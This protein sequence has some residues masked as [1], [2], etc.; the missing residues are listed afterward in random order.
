MLNAEQ[1]NDLIKKDT[2]RQKIVSDQ[3]AYVRG[4][5]P[6][7]LMP[8]PK[9][10]PDN[11]IPVPFAR[12][13]VETV[14]GYLA[15]P[16]NIVYKGEGY[17]ESLKEVFEEND[18]ELETAE[19]LRTALTYGESYELHWVEN[20]QEQFKQVP[21]AQCVALWS[22]SL[23]PTMT[24]F[25]RYWIDKDGNTI[26]D[27]YDAY[28]KQ[29]YIKK[30]NSQ[31]FVTDGQSME[32]GYGRVP[33]TRY[34]IDPNGLNVF[35]HVTAL[36]D[37]FD[38][39]ISENYANDLQ[40]LSSAI[41]LLAG[42]LNTNDEDSVDG[43]A[44]SEKVVTGRLRY[45]DGL[46]SESGNVTD[47]VAYLTKNIDP[48]FPGSAAAIIE[49]LIYEMLQLFNPND[50]AFNTPSGV[51]AQYKLIGFEYLC[52]K[53]TTYF[54]RGLNDRI[55][56]IKGIGY[57]LT[58]D[59][60][61]TDVIIDWKRNLPNDIKQLSE[62][63]VSLD[64]ILSKETILHMFPSYIVENVEDEIEKLNGEKESDTI[65]IY[66]K[67]KPQ[68]KSVPMTEDEED[69]ASTLNGDTE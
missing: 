31:E 14:C 48:A 25:V 4:L 69:L 38:K 33:V 1:L 50:E 61:N 41:L 53:I 22:D 68:E 32:H 15:K 44:D 47:K 12:R 30:K 58:G 65:D 37:F 9:E 67:E 19:L 56:I 63:A 51:A 35:D 39:L 18:E 13:A 2:K 49:R 17:D 11:R 46:V 7:I 16:G 10:N 26:S 8:S 20:G 54:S 34:I 24:E 45:L 3:T 27:I 36:I 52:T 55:K 66:A 60:Q 59:A 5:N 64:G 57:A 23:K 43:I 21:I 62:I 42:R 29:R 40:S 28:V 6:S